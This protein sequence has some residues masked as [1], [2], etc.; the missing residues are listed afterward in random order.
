MEGFDIDGVQMR[1]PR[2]LAD[3]GCNITFCTGE[4]SKNDQMKLLEC[5]SSLGT[6][7]YV[8]DDAQETPP[9][10]NAAAYEGK[11][12]SKRL[13][14][15]LFVKYSQLGGENKLGNWREWYEAQI[16]KIV[17]HIQSTLDPN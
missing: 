5:S 9:K 7:I 17:T 16:S 3:K 1:P 12:P 13:Y 6:L 14:D 11:T 10:L 8:P 2:F 15:T 4:M